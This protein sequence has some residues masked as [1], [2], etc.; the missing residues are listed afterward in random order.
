MGVPRLVAV[1][2]YPS[3]LRES[4]ALHPVVVLEVGLAVLLDGSP[5]SLS[6]C[7]L[8]LCSCVHGALLLPSVQAAAAEPGV[9]VPRNQLACTVLFACCPGSAITC[10]KTRVAV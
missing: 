8:S 9:G 7:M 5:G 3:M 1:D 6:S 4:F 10:N 2:I